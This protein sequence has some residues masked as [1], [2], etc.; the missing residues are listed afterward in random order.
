MQHEY[1]DPFIRFLQEKG[2]KPSTLK[3]YISDLEKFF[4]WLS[5]YKGTTINEEIL[6]SLSDQDLK[7]YVNELNNQNLSDASFRR[8]ISVLNQFLRFLNLDP[9]TIIDKPKDRP[10]RSLKSK[11]F[12]S[13]KEMQQLLTSMKKSNNS[14][15]RDHLIERNLAIVCLSRYYG[16]TPKDISSITMNNIN[17]AQKTID[18]NTSKNTLIIKLEEEHIQY[19][20]DYLYSIEKVLRPRLRT[21]DPLFVSFFNLTCRFH[22]DYV[23]GMPKG[24]SIRG[25]QEMIKDEVR[26]A[27][28]RKISAKHLRNSCIIDHLSRGFSDEAIISFFRLSNSFSLRRYKEYIKYISTSK[29]N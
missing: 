16:L 29:E 3:Q 17:L 15:A 23:A 1:L 25:I 19:I 7:S 18:I 26:I 6:R 14:I 21:K 12:I 4:D 9:G 20:R 27:R 8:L 10:L 11:D 13:K 22:F 5:N 24:L 28:L 2:R